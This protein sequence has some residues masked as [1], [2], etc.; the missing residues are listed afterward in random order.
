MSDIS[1]V[2][3]D[4]QSFGVKDAEARRLA[5]ALNN[6]KANKTDIGSPLVASTVAGMTDSTRIYVYTGTE[7]GY[8]KG[9][10]Y[11]HDASS[12]TWKS[13]GVYNSIALETDKTLTQEGVP[14]D[15]RTVGE[16]LRTLE[17]Q[18]T[19]DKTEIE[20]NM[21]EMA[22]IYQTTGNMYSGIS[23]MHKDVVDDTKEVKFANL[24]AK[25]YAKEA[26]ET[27]EAI[28]KLQLLTPEQIEGTEVQEARGG[29][30]TLGTRLNM[31]AYKYDVRN[32]MLSD[33][34]L[35]DGDIAMVFGGTKLN[36][37]HQRVFKVVELNDPQSIAA[38]DEWYELAAPASR[39]GYKLYAFSIGGFG[40]GSGSGGTDGVRFELQ[41]IGDTVYL[42]VGSGLDV[43]FLYRSGTKAGTLFYSTNGFT[44]SEM[45]L[46]AAGSY[47]L[48]LPEFN[49]QSAVTLRM[50]IVDSEGEMSETRAVT[51]RVGDLSA[52]VITSVTEYTDADDLIV[53]WKINDIYGADIISH[54]ALYRNSEKIL[55]ST[56]AGNVGTN[57]SYNFGKL[58]AGHYIFRVYLTNTNGNTSKTD[59]LVFNVSSNK[60][61]ATYLLNPSSEFNEN[62]S[63]AFSYALL[64]NGTGSFKT[65]VYVDTALIEEVN[66]YVGSNNTIVLSNIGVGSHTL[67]LDTSST[68]GMSDSLTYE[69][70]VVQGVESV[71]EPITDGLVVS[72]DS[73]FKTNNKSDK[74]I[75]K[76]E[77]ADISAQL[78]NF[79][80]NTNGWVSDVVDNDST[81]VV[82]KTNGYDNYAKLN[83]CP[84]FSTDL[85]MVDGMTI[86][87]KFKNFNLGDSDATIMECLDQNNKGFRITNN[88]AIFNPFGSIE[89]TDNT[90]S[91]NLMSDEWVR[92]AF[93]VVKGMNKTG[94]EIY[95]YNFYTDE[96]LALVVVNGTIMGV[97][98]GDIDSKL[99]MNSRYPIY[100]G[101]HFNQ[102]LGYTQNY[103]KCEIQHVRIYNQKLNTL[104][105]LNNFI[106]DLH[107]TTLQQYYMALNDYSA[108]GEPGKAS[109]TSLP[110]LMIDGCNLKTLDL[111][112]SMDESG[113][114]IG[115]KYTYPNVDITLSDPSGKLG[116]PGNQL[117]GYGCSVKAQ[118]TSSMNYKV[119]NYKITYYKYNKHM[120]TGDIL[121][122]GDS[123]G[124][125]LVTPES[126]TF[127]TD[128]IYLSS[129]ITKLVGDGNTHVG[130]NLNEIGKKKVVPNVN[131]N[132]IAENT[133]CLK[134]DYMESSHARN[135]GN[136][137]F[138]Q[139]YMDR[140]LPP[141]MAVSANPY[142]NANNDYQHV[143]CTISG[144][145][146]VVSY[147]T[148]EGETIYKGIYNF[149]MDKGCSEHF[150]F[151]AY[152][153]NVDTSKP[154]D[155]S[156]VK[157]LSYEIGNN[158]SGGAA[159]FNV[160]SSTLAGVQ[161]IRDDFE[162]RYH[163][164]EKDGALDANEKLVINNDGS[165]QFHSHLVHLVD[166]VY[167]TKNNPE[168]FNQQLSKHF[169]E[170]T[171]V[172]YYLYTRTLC[173]ADNLGKNCML[174][175]W[176]ADEENIVKKSDGSID[177]VNSTF[178]KWYIQFYDLDTCVGLDNAGHNVYGITHDI[179]GH[180]ADEH[181]PENDL[182]VFNTSDSVLWC[183]LEA[184]RETK[185][186]D[187]YRAIR[188][189]LFTPEKVMNALLGNIVNKIG[190]YY[191]NLDTLAKYF[192]MLSDY[193]YM[194]QGS[195]YSHIKKWV[196]D[197]FYYM[198]S[199]FG[200][201]SSGIAFRNYKRADQETTDV[202]F[203]IKV[204]VPQYI[205]VQY[206]DNILETKLCSDTDYT[207]F[208]KSISGS[209]SNMTISGKEFITELTGMAQCNAMELNFNNARSLR[210]LD[211]SGCGYLSSLI[212]GNN[213]W[214]R[215]I[216]LTSTEKLT[217]E[218]D[219]STLSE[220]IR[221]RAKG[222]GITGLTLF[223]ASG[224]AGNLKQ[225][226]IQ[227]TSVY[228]L[229]ADTVS[230][231]VSI[232]TINLNSD[233]KSESALVNAL[234]TWGITEE[235][236]SML[237][238][239]M[240]NHL[241]ESGLPASEANNYT[242][243]AD[244]YDS[245]KGSKYTTFTDLFVP[246]L[247]MFKPVVKMGTIDLNG[248]DLIDAIY[249]SPTA[250]K[251]GA[252]TYP[253]ATE[254]IDLSYMENL[255]YLY[256]NYATSQI[257]NTSGNKNL[258]YVYMNNLTEI[259][260]FNIA[261]S[262]K[263][264]HLQLP[265]CSKLVTLI[266]NYESKTL[267]TLNLN[268]C[269]S[270]SVVKYG[271]SDTTTK[272][273]NLS[274][275]E[276]TSISFQTMLSMPTITNLK[277]T[278][279]NLANIFYTD[280]RYRNT[281]TTNVTGTITVTGTG[282]AISQFFYGFNNLVFNF[283]QGLNIE[284][285]EGA[286][287]SGSAYRCIYYCYKFSY[288]DLCY[289][290][291]K[292]GYVSTFQEAFVGDSGIVTTTLPANLFCG[293][294]GTGHKHPTAN[295]ENMFGG[296]SGMAGLV[297]PSGIF[298]PLVNVTTATNWC[299]SG[300]VT[301]KNPYVSNNTGISDGNSSVT[302]S[303]ISGT[304][305]AGLFDYM[306]KLQTMSNFFAGSTITIADIDNLFVKAKALRSLINVFAGAK[307]TLTKAPTK[308]M[309]SGLTNITDI[310]GLFRS[311]NIAFSSGTIPAQFFS[312]L[313]NLTNI[314]YAL[315]GCDKVTSFG[316]GDF[317][318]SNSKL[319][320]LNFM[321][322][323]TG[324]SGTIPNNLLPTDGSSSRD[325]SGLLYGNSNLGNFTS[326]RE[327]GEYTNDIPSNFF[328]GQ[329]HVTSIAY[330]FGNC[331]NLS[332][333]L[334]TG[335]YWFVDM[336]ALLNVSGLFYNDIGL[337]NSIPAYG[338][339]ERL[340]DFYEQSTDENDETIM[341]YKKNT[342]RTNGF[343]ACK[344]SAGNFVD[345]PI[346]YASAVF[347][348]CFN[349]NGA[350]PGN[351][352]AR[353]S[354]LVNAS[355]MFYYCKRIGTL[356]DASVH[357]S[358]II[359]VNNRHLAYGL[360]D[361]CVALTN[362][363]GMFAYCRFNG[364][365]SEKAAA[366]LNDTTYDESYALPK[367][368]F[369]FCTELENVSS[370]FRRGWTSSVTTEDNEDFYIS[371]M[372]GRFYPFMFMYNISL[373]NASDMF[374][375]C[376]KL[377]GYRTATSENGVDSNIFSTNKH[378]QYMNGM[379]YATAVG[380][381]ERGFIAQRKQIDSIKSVANVFSTG[382]LQ[383]NY[384]STGIP[385]GKQ[386]VYD[387]NT[388]SY[389]SFYDVYGIYAVS[390]AVG[391]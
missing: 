173:L 301:V 19:T 36:D 142:Y 236:R 300:S 54:V 75:W 116:L 269:S 115:K 354:R 267:K 16:S 383:T 52:T 23:D 262:S 257:I 160:D 89:D 124:G 363:A 167:A 141:Q 123:E 15:S 119:K 276:L 81:S 57:N 264:V 342:N 138:L 145:P 44:Y 147:R 73:R 3:V 48:S 376:D 382:I 102:Q 318:R 332:I 335:S 374:D 284:L 32:E 152:N 306:T 163:P 105:L 136:A 94:A 223:S 205:T 210:K 72:L 170:D 4:S 231:I 41:G 260:T 282:A 130:G 22:S 58:A 368:L 273:M 316:T 28:E 261:E 120:S 195:G 389:K 312:G 185:L 80:F 149:N 83:Y 114:Y 34:H 242:T 85:G 27:K 344:D 77:D 203:G 45:Q 218:V 378:I 87:I 5:A 40:T 47:T 6:T 349:L 325:L 369:K 140:N 225:L 59:I 339:V 302:K 135:L 174:T 112:T 1:K 76:D 137:T 341:V 334:N 188:T 336:R 364:K 12:N 283:G 106:A 353:M 327:S 229:N 358:S 97:V 314:S 101:A 254:E 215:D 214:L 193:D 91:V 224:K 178:A 249:I 361:D 252:A 212:L 194:A 219:V 42:E 372:N 308:A 279:T 289:L 238:N 104:E 71:V 330:L 351:L 117:I 82:L 346:I 320:S 13:G 161:S 31:F 328:S 118:G 9:N 305:P 63:I 329:T 8:V 221:F 213:V 324:L 338:Y 67:R 331:P 37:G 198:D 181:V 345:S 50:Y 387:V 209:D 207:V 30:A 204:S 272:G 148:L 155:M 211:L 377:S 199:V 56:Q 250:K 189:N 150:G 317:I 248:N 111:M 182:I 384:G 14:A 166:W 386:M 164:Y 134:A 292:L 375:Y 158:E 70:S 258:T 90:I 278:V 321:L 153:K 294:V 88:K 202:S 226:D 288:R 244:F 98:A 144:F 309:F 277:A 84:F 233:Y 297:L 192:S 151:K 187:T 299:T 259:T 357:G 380:M 326:Q 11:Y 21:E 159:G 51:I 323:K 121:W 165:S 139:S 296:C 291:D 208:Q 373:T 49:V 253:F 285:A 129:Q 64:Y 93:V 290:M 190:Q 337:H 172:K 360:L 217:S 240:R 348:Q 216:D 200:Y 132:W 388:D 379:F 197:R 24:E 156:K 33:L 362:V 281:V 333:D 60:N 79:D 347:Y 154:S 381:V 230:N 146:V 352:L 245:N 196:T 171:L 247:V 184:T 177:W 271:M 232:G 180:T 265:N 99:P 241:I 371:D 340:D 206:G 65:K 61:I 287:I 370:M 179:H 274:R 266:L 10:W 113:A 100:F 96:D 237:L 68:S 310:T 251:A 127:N 319:V 359:Q 227:G 304:V 7:S 270:L 175:T 263:L 385:V 293:N 38:E 66:A 313:T 256:L 17:E 239:Q 107:N 122:Y 103:A 280:W 176:N 110:S 303:N 69:F 311:S 95:D 2:I 222:S 86:E 62:A 356:S 43:G 343:F 74:N 298:D 307:L 286:K 243:F 255:N 29:R 235:H 367:Y 109:A 246:G 315:C 183:N 131:G 35:R 391:Y 295:I 128:G 18:F 168:M 169:D 143:Q 355:N 26:R 126:S 157:C 20:A 275:F 322:A 201:G 234:N 228:N 220:L 92:V 78:Y 186:K 53:K 55:E 350:V 108:S 191:Y 125:H 133:F 366:D 39:T 162:L 390:S 268:Y 365:S 46:P 25:G